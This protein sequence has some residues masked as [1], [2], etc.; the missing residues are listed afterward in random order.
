MVAK[1]VLLSAL[2]LCSLGIARGDGLTYIVAAYGTNHPQPPEGYELATLADVK[3]DEFRNFTN[4][5]SL[6]DTGLNN[7]NACCVFKVKEGYLTM[8][9]LVPGDFSFFGP[10]TQEE[11]W[12]CYVVLENPVMLGTEVDVGPYADE[13]I[14]NLTPSIQ[15]IMGTWPTTSGFGDNFCANDH[16]NSWAI[17]KKL[18]PL[19][20]VAA[21]NK[22]DPL[23]DG[24][25]IATLADIKSNSFIQF[26]NHYQLEDTGVSNNACCVFTVK[27]GYLAIGHPG[28]FSFIAPFNKRGENGCQAVLSN[29]VMFGG[30]VDVGPYQGIFINQLANVIARMLMTW[31]TNQGFG[32]FCQGIKVDWAIMKRK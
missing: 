22:V 16:N 1:I 11:E 2:V 26:Y 8:G 14:G 10:W 4:N 21:N 17:F 23:P 20:K 7:P 31:P 32:D 5:N 15:S 12:G 28:N 27:E 19:F 6:T 29:P 30:A 3:S 25:E 9:K 24:Y 18:P 13:F